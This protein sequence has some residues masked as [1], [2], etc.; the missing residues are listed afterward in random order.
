MTLILKNFSGKA[1]DWLNGILLLLFTLMCIY[2][3]YYVL[4]YSI[5]DPAKV[6]QGIFLL[7]AGL[8]F[9]TYK[10]I[11]SLPYIKTSFFI[12]LSRT[13]IGTLLTVLCCSFFSYLLTKDRMLLRKFVYR[14]LVVTLYINAGL[15]PWYITM[16]MLHLD[17]NFLLYVLP[18]AVSGFNVILIKTYIEQLP[19]ALEESAMIDGA[20]YLTIF[21][22]IIFPLCKPIVATVAVFAAVGQWNTWMDNY[23]L[24]N[25]ASLK[26]IQLTLYEFLSSANTFTGLDA[27]SITRQAQNVVLTPES[28]KMSTTIIVT[29]PILAVYPFMQRYFVKGIMLGAVKG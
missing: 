5:S 25:S 13:V 21:T 8:E 24:V 18:T 12:S 19:A 23:F 22:K 17:E 28:I 29:L 2:P 14:M 11:L 15:I 3:F 10:S 20:G 16:K 27:A 9:G 26:T 1:F 6:A 4:I 7:P